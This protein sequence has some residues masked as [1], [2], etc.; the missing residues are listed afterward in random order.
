[1]HLAGPEPALIVLGDRPPATPYLV[2]ASHRVTGWSREAARV[3]L[4]LSGL[5]PKQIELAGL[6]ADREIAVEISDGAGTRRERPRT[7]RDGHLTVH[8]GEAADVDVRLG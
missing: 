1:M 4:R 7:G 6:P 8:A 5:G 3:K 2:H